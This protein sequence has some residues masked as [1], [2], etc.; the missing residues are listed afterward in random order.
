MKSE[1]LEVDFEGNDLKRFYI[2]DEIPVFTRQFGWNTVNPTVYDGAIVKILAYKSDI[3]I[4]SL[5]GLSVASQTFATGTTGTDF[6]ISSAGSVHTFNLPDASVTARGLI[7]TGLQSF[8]GDKTLTGITK[9]LS[10][11]WNEKSFVMVVMEGSAGLLPNSRS[12][13]VTK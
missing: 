7:T 3:G 6:G 5:N 8:A 13:A 10:I 2:P 11:V 12:S 9:V 4:T 1:D